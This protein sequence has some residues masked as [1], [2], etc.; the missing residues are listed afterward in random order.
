MIPKEQMIL[1]FTQNHRPRIAKVVQRKKNKGRGTSS[2]T[3]DNI[4]NLQ[5][6]KDAGIGTKTD[7][8]INRPKQ[9][10]QKCAHIPTVN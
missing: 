3:S 8:W 10:G 6:S 1:K 5:Y 7:V 4:A 9:R 2:Q